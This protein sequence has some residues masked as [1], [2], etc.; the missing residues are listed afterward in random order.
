MPRLANKVALIT[1]AA[2]GQGTAEAELFVREGAGVVLTD[3]DAEAGEAL[4]KRLTGR[5]GKAIFRVQ[6][7]AS[8]E[9]WQDTVAAALSTFGG[10]HILVNNAGT[11][12]RQGIVATTIDAWNRTLAVNLT[13]PMLGMKHCA[14]AMRDAGGGSIVNISSTAGLTAHDDA[15]YTATK[16][17][18]RGLTKTAVLQF[19]DW[20]IRVN[21]IHPGQ[22]ADT[23][24]FRSGGEAFAQ[25]AAAAIPMHRQGTPRECA[26]L[27]LF[28]ASDEASFISGAEIAIDG[29][30]I[31]AGLAG[32][33]NRIRDELM[34]R[35]S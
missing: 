9:S 19:S 22:I 5:G 14:P 24:F 27:V 26:E 18:L 6:D 29:G 1:G 3:I 4:A 28:L 30:Y 35:N 23:G 2:G 34:R 25:A 13:G 7:V 17:G 10:L 20:K 15:A 31:A 16:W 21:S 33:R 32:M 8:E 11:I 12:A